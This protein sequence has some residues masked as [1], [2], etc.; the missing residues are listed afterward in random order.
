MM[1]ENVQAMLEI[2]LF[3]VSILR[4]A[5]NPEYLSHIMF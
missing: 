2:F 3:F 4:N 1:L 5:Q